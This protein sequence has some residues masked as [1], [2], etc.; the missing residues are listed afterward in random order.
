MAT[1]AVR[2]RSSKSSW[3]RA[4]RAAR[5][6]FLVGLLAALLVFAGGA[7]WLAA[8]S[9][10][11]FVY[12]LIWYIEFAGKE[13]GI[14]PVIAMV[15]TAQ[16]LVGPYFAYEYGA[17]TTKYYMYV[18][19]QSYFQFVFPSVVL[20]IFGLLI[21]APRIE[22][23]ALRHRLL[24][25]RP[26][27]QRTAYLILVGSLVGDLAGSFLPASLAFVIFLVG[28]VKF[29]ALF[30]LLVYRYKYRW[31]ACVAV[32]GLALSQAAATGFFHD[33]ILWAA[34]L[35]SFV[36]FDLRLSLKTKILVICGCIIGIVQIQTIK[37]DYRSLIADNPSKAGIVSLLTTVRDSIGVAKFNLS[38]LNA[39]LNQGWIISALM[40]NVPRNVQFEEG[41]TVFA[42]IRDSLLPRFLLDK[43]TVNMS[44]TFRKYSGIEVSDN[45]TFGISV[46]GEI[47]INFGAFGIFF[48]LI[49][50]MIY[51]LVLKLAT[52]VANI[53]P[54][55]VLWSPL[56]FLQ[57]V[58]AETE[59]VVV[60]NHV[61]KSFIF[62]VCIYFVVQK[63]LK[64][65]I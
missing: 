18:D 53:W 30:Y 56:L 13:I 7:Y 15:A 4:L 10:G 41:A 46:I 44:E 49:F 62:V 21:A 12:C 34:L 1:A 33:L 17:V 19:E 5:F 65:K 6:Q 35:F 28:E 61:V 14:V 55:F 58:K 40:Y 29:I 39:R 59:L 48:M 64:V 25:L 63:I 45:T 42:A 36:S 57:A 27:P 22:C 31:L 38:E 8:L 32:F 24:T 23:A 3:F 43:P 51:G 52:I 20:F 11:T 2:P 54:T 26:L 50:G 9:V 60:L 47:W 16:W 37:G